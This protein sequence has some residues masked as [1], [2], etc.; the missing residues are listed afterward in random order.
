MMKKGSLM[1]TSF[2]GLARPK[3]DL[4]RHPR[5]LL[6]HLAVVEAFLTL[7]Y[8]GVMSRVLGFDAMYR[9]SLK[10]V[11]PSRVIQSYFNKTDMFQICKDAVQIACLI[12]PW[13]AL[14]LP[15]SFAIYS[16]L[17]RRGIPAKIAI[18]VEGLSLRP[19][20]WVECGET[21]IDTIRDTQEGLVKFEVR[22]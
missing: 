15:R 19:H 6:L 21:A 12:L 20:A 1:N 7:L 5:K 2:Q 9:H 18:G 10:E 17:K 22:N 4:K 3:R 13:R 8:V 16:M 14:C 11:R